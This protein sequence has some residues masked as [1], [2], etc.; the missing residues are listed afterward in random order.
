MAQFTR[1]KIVSVTP[2]EFVAFALDPANAPRVVPN[3]V[4][5]VQ[6]DDGPVQVGTVFRETRRQ[7]NG[8]STTDLELFELDWER[9]Y[10][11][12]AEVSGIVVVYRYTAT[13]CT[14]G[15]RVEMCCEVTG[16]GVKKL[17]VPLVL[18]VLEK[19]DGDQLD[20]LER[21][22]RYGK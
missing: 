16:R 6:L 17:M 20:R 10:A 12:R 19:M 8:T 13:P 18:K 4:S 22:R 21:V 14:A 5:M 15:T 1:E 3:V 2:S 11:V 9:G 7:K